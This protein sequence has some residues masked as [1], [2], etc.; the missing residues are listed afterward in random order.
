MFKKLIEKIKEA[1]RRMVAY[2]D[3]NDSIDMVMYTIS[4]EMQQAIADWTDIYM[5]KPYWKDEDS[6]IFTLG[7][8]KTICQTLQSQVLSEMESVILSESEVEPTEGANTRASYLNEQYEKHLLNKLSEKLEVAMATGGM[9][10]KPYVSGSE[11]YVD[12]CRQGTFVPVGFDDDGNITDIVFPDSFI[13]DGFVYTKIERQIF[14]SVNHTITIENRAYR[15][16]VEQNDT[17]SQDLGI[18]I[19]LE[20][21]TKWASLEPETIIEDVERPLFG[22][23]RVPL[24]NN[25][26]ID[27]PL[28]ISVFS[29]AVDMIRRADEQFSRLD[30]EYEGGQLAIDVDVSALQ[31][32]EGYYGTSFNLDK[33]RQRLY[34]TLDLG[35]DDT[36]KEFAPSLRDANFMTGLEKYLMRIED[37]IGLARGSLSEVGAEARTATEIRILKQRTYI[38]ISSN[39]TAL[40]NALNDLVYAMDALATLYNLAPQG[41]YNFNTEWKDSVLTDT[42]EELNQRLQLLDAGVESKIELRMW[43]KG[44]DLET[45]TEAIRQIDEAN[46]SNLMNDIFSGMTEAPL[47]NQPQEE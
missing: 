33:A 10:F 37:M 34:R 26:D 31:V 13:A 44:E 22:Y 1:L 21:V 6:G 8:G 24:A 41:D 5:D 39:Q 17:D 35:Q 12:F 43:Y 42:Q 30:W 38:T 40:E 36:Y 3:I 19:P 27:S 20:A 11:I 15:A 28:G 9:I 29:P 32:T 45:A 18:E 7:L 23:Y 4:E 2:K 46:T 16:K 25:I 14:D 47:D